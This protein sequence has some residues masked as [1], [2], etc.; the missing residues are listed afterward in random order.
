MDNL[1]LNAMIAEFVKT[2][3][4]IH[5]VSASWQEPLVAIADANDPLFYALKKLISP[6]HA[7]PDDLVAG[8]QSV[9]AFFI[10]FAPMINQSN[11]ANTV[12]SKEWAVA[13]IETNRLIRDLNQFI[14]TEFEHLGYKCSNVPATHNFDENSLLSDWSHKHVGYI[15]G[16]GQFG[17]HQMLITKRGCSGRLGSIVTN[18]QLQPTPRPN[19]AY[20]L[21]RFNQTCHLCVTKC[22]SGALQV[23]TFDRRRCYQS[24]LD[25]AERYNV[26]G[27]ADV[28]GKCM[29]GVPCAFAKTRFKEGST[30]GGVVRLVIALTGIGGGLLWLCD[31]ALIIFSRQIVRIFDA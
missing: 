23:D 15:A 24:C 30:T 16:L 3:P 31:L 26:L 20:C 11:V 25:N 5:P 19:Q 27:L 1:R 14:R 29:S 28:C 7:L 12:S 9:I 2:Y 6:N 13:Y 8:A 17:L 10:P 18:M 4:T 22:L 21:Y